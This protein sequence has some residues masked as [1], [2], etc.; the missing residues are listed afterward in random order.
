MGLV[1]AYCILRFARLKFLQAKDSLSKQM[2]ALKESLEIT[3]CKN[4]WLEGLM[5]D[6]KTDTESLR[7]V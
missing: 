6:T 3:R 2:S 4:S 7:Q 5:N 1:K